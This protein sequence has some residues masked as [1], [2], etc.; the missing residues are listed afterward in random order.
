[1]VRPKRLYY[2]LRPLLCCECGAA[3]SPKREQELKHRRGR[4]VFCSH[5]CRSA[6]WGRFSLAR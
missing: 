5:Q 2:P 4:R 3:F 6:N 1:M